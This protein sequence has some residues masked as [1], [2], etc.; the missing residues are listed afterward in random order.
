[1]KNICYESTGKC[2]LK[3]DY[4]ISADNLNSDREEV[5]YEEI[6]KVISEFDPQRIVIS[7]GEPML[8]P[9]LS[10]KLKIIRQS[11][12]RAFLSI[13]TNGACEYDYESIMEYIDCI[14]FSLPALNRQ[15]Y[16][17]MRGCDCI[18]I[19]K[20]NIQK[21]K[22]GHSH[23]ELRL[24]YTLTKVNKEEL[25]DI[26]EFAS[27]QGVDELR[28]GR[29]FPFRDA[30]LCKDKYEL[31]DEEINDVRDFINSKDY[32]FRMVPPIADLECMEAG[33][34]AINYLGEIFLPSREGKRKL[35]EVGK[36]SKAEIEKIE[37]AIEQ[38]NI[39]VSTNMK[40]KEMEIDL[41][42]MLMPKRIRSSQAEYQ[43]STI[44]EY[45]SD[46][47][48]ILYSQAFRR[49][50]QKAQ[51]FSL[52]TN[53]SVRSRLSHSIEVSDVGRLMAQK[54]TRKLVE[55]PDNHE[56]HLSSEEA[57]Q[58]VAIVENAGLMHDL[59]NPPF[60]HFGEAAIQKWWSENCDK[61]IKAYN[62]RAKENNENAISFTTKQ[63]KKILQDF[64][65]FDGNPQ[66]IR[67]V[68]R[69][70]SDEKLEINDD[71]KKKELESESGMNLTYQT[72][73]SCIKYIRCAGEEY[74]AAIS[75]KLQKK[76][77]CFQSEKH[78][79]YRMQ[80]ELSRSSV[81]RFPF[82]YIMEAADDISYCMSDVADSIEKGLTTLNR[83]VEDLDKIWYEKYEKEIPETIIDET[84]RDD[85]KEGRKKDINTALTSG[86]AA[87]LTEIAADRF[88]NGIDGFMKGEAEE[89][90]SGTE[91]ADESEK[92]W[93]RLLEVINEYAR[94]KI[95]T[96]AEAESIEIAGYSIIRGLLDTFGKLL[97]LT[98]EEFQFLLNTQNNPKEKKLD[99]EV[100]YV[101]LLGK[102]YI[103]SYENQ[104]REW[105]K[106]PHEGLSD[107]Q[108][109]WW[110]R[111]HLVVD[112]VAGMTDDYAL[113]T[114]QLCK[115]IYVGPAK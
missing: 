109:E 101:H 29:F 69:F 75:R 35:A 11:C 1:M 55:L 47:S 104:I 34:L 106:I 21:I 3:C 68:L 107:E 31:S 2:N 115:G 14:D 83:F 66:G 76:A 19:V 20:E 79:I 103:H 65:E 32:P 5:S 51:V 99:V 60:G 95:Y 105:K 9:E 85:I 6:I 81:K 8:D 63:Q 92:P 26:L 98:K 88:V 22:E 27:K 18:E 49:L 64:Q 108:I 56:Y 80:E 74:E 46:R 113:K 78:I 45:Y 61:Y 90:F 12:P 102:K 57:E 43:R 110:L 39:F 33:Y 96:A 44:E 114:Y 52:E 84:K 13:S 73:L 48:R 97:T 17:E 93:C 89:I 50:Q 82:V 87:K 54:I 62:K 15:I 36:L 23:C 86:W 71:K 24:S 40:K 112:H 94:R 38:N 42:Q 30:A 53:A 7:G 16:A 25:P 91:T 77:G 70:N 37:A 72:V 100:R 67:T 59:G 41:H 4:C 111:A 58:V 10:A 28:I